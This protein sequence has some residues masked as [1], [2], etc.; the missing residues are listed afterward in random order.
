MDDGVPVMHI[1][2]HLS[3]L[4]SVLVLIWL[5]SSREWRSVDVYVLPIWRYACITSAVHHRCTP[6]VKQAYL[7]INSTYT[8]TLPRIHLKDVNHLKSTPTGPLVCVS[9]L[10]HRSEQYTTVLQQ[11]LLFKPNH[12][13]GHPENYYFFIIQQIFSGSSYQKSILFHFE[14]RSTGCN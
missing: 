1:H 4:R 12:W 2:I 3:Y 10:H 6:K 9:S 13:L 11:V 7:Q 8:S 5:Y 14:N